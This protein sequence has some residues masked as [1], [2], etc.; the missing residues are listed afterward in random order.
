MHKKPLIS[1]II[2]V[3]N[4]ERYLPQCIDSIIAQT[5]HDWELILVDDGSTDRSGAICDEYS[6]KDTRI[7]VIH[8]QNS[9]QADSRNIAIQMAEAE[10]VG[11][12][13]SDDFIHRQTYEIALKTAEK[14]NADI[15]QWPWIEFFG[16]NEIK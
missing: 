1:I 2:P 8:K 14:Y 3:Y 15:V 11:F 13:D 4:V 6:L 12:V 5:F 10:L 9:G 7:R 16:L